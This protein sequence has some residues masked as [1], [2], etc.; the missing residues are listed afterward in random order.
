MC[1]KRWPTSFSIPKIIITEVEL[2]VCTAAHDNW[3]IDKAKEAQTNAKKVCGNKLI[4]GAAG[5]KEHEEM[6]TVNNKIIIE[7]CKNLV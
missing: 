4:N 1:F 5:E 2:S 6:H 7:G 3:M